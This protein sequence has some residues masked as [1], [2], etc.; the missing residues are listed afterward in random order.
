M[1]GTLWGSARY[2][3]LVWSASINML[4][5]MWKSI[6]RWDGYKLQDKKMQ[7]VTLKALYVARC[8][9]VQSCSKSC[10]CRFW[11]YNTIMN[12]GFHGDFTKWGN[13]V[14]DQW[15]SALTMDLKAMWWTVIW[16]TGH[17]MDSY[18]I[19]RYYRQIHDWQSIDWQLTVTSFVWYVSDFVIFLS[20]IL[21]TTNTL[22]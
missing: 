21:D 13:A 9:H 4:H 15:P 16:L 5:T 3:W 12:D 17:V 7:E 19:D 6:G 10:Y 2:A 18:T 22:R 11:A 14:G 1:R 20:I 8:A